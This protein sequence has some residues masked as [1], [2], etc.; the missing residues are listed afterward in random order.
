M[1]HEVARDGRVDATCIDCTARL[2]LEFLRENGLQGPTLAHVMKQSNANHPRDI[3][4]N[5]YPTP[6]LFP[7]CSYGFPLQAH[8]NPTIQAPFSALELPQTPLQSN[9]ISLQLPFTRG[10]VVGAAL[11]GENT[12]LTHF[13]HRRRRDLLLAA[14]ARFDRRL[15]HQTSFPVISLRPS[16]LLARLQSDLSSQYDVCS[17][18]VVLRD[19]VE[20][21]GM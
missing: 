4:Q 12:H 14:P 18:R 8:T 16:T 20:D 2:K 17:W 21:G 13:P 1:I 9:A 5:S 10:R 15:A 6:V 3:A 7:K 11:R 19:Y